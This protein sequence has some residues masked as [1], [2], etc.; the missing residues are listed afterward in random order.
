ML[1]I[2]IVSYNSYFALS[3]F[4]PDL[5]REP[6]Y[7]VI[8]ID[9]ASTD[10]TPEKIRSAF[11]K[12]ECI[13]LD[14]NIGYGRAANIGLSKIS[15]QYALILNPDIQASNALI[16]RL[17]DKALKY[18]NYAAIFA[19][20]TTQVEE[21]GVVEII[22]KEW[23][24][25]AAL[26]FDMEQMMSVGY[27]DENIFLYYEE[28]DLCKRVRDHGKKVA[29][30]PDVCFPHIKETSTLSS[31]VLD[32]LRQWHVAWSSMYFF[33]K[34]DLT[35][36]K[37]AAWRLILQYLLKAVFTVTSRKRRKYIA[38]VRGATAFVF[39]KQAFDSSGKARASPP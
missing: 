4:M 9:N 11:P 34:H 22:E 23:V 39:G 36:G 20:A 3:Q 24:L 10:G 28:V 7:P 5:L 6:D 14:S 25:G 18:K 1:T 19:H 32:H 38:R 26:L 15:S 8:I 30:L 33:R 17:L 16:A 21:G 2:I 35:T 31:P 29:L 13:A 37:R 12:V 27:F